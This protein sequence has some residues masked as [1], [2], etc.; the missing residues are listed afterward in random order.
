MKYIQGD[1]RKHLFEEL[2]IIP[3]I[4]NNQNLNC[5]GVTIALNE[6]WGFIKELKE[7]Y[8]ELE[9]D[10][11]KFSPDNDVFYQQEWQLGQVHFYKDGNVV[12]AS[13]IAQTR[14]GGETIADTYLRPIR[15]DSLRECMLRVR[16]F[17]KM[18]G[19]TNI[20]AP[21]FG[22]LRAGGNWEEEIIPMI[23]ELWG[24]LDITIYEYKE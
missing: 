23:N 7:F 8:R 6:K 3:H 17:A 9:W 4:I 13:M 18:I 14:P 15:L 2:T 24:N 11:C 22:S 5:S 20:V 1:I 10:H 16:Q 19:C 21:K 12:I